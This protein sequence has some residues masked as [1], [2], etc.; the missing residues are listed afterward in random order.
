[1]TTAEA[2]ARVEA[3]PDPEPGDHEGRHKLLDALFDLS[4]A[5]IADGSLETWDDDQIREYLDRSRT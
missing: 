4:E 5:M 2:I 1:M 3:I